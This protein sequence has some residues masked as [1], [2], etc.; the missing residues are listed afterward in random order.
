MIVHM[1]LHRSARSGLHHCSALLKGGGGGGRDVGGSG[2]VQGNSL[3][4]RKARSCGF[5][6]DELL[7]K[8]AFAPI[9]SVWMSVC[10]LVGWLA[11]LSQ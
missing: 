5:V 3:V 2:E 9:S 8:K 7:I 1:Q 4:S 10:F 6:H 11:C